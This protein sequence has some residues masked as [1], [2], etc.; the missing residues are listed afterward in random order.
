M[1]HRA[2]GNL[3][4]LA[5]ARPNRLAW[6]PEA[7]TLAERGFNIDTNF[8]MGIYAPAN[9]PAARLDELQAALADVMA[10]PEVLQRVHALGFDET[11][12]MS[13]DFSRIVKASTDSWKNA[14]QESGFK[15]E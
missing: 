14:I 9:L 4:V 8:W 13:R 12:R 1:E 5:A 7:P 11:V 15:P 10:R 2:K 3:R 6:A